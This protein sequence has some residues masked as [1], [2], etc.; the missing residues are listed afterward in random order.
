MFDHIDC[1][2]TNVILINFLQWCFI[3]VYIFGYID[4]YNVVL[5]ILNLIVDKYAPNIMT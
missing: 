5:V 1:I 4:S 2:K 3:S